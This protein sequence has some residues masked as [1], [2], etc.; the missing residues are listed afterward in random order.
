MQSSK[1]KFAILGCGRIGHRHI[2]M[3]E[4][5]QQTELV[6]LI[7]D[8]PA[9]E[10][11]GAAV[12]PFFNSLGD[13][14]ASGITCDVITIAT[15]NGLHAGHALACLDHGYHVLVEKPLALKSRDANKLME[16]SNATGKC[17]F[18]V[19]QNRFSKAAEWTKAMVQSDALGEIF[20][21]QANCFWNRDA[22]YYEGHEWHGDRQLDGGPLYTQFA[23][24]IDM[25]FWLFGDIE[26]IHGKAAN[27][28]HEGITDFADTGLLQFELENGG[29]GCL[30]FTTAVWGQNFESYIS[31]MGEKGTVKI[32]GQYLQNIGYC[33]VQDV[34]CPAELSQ[35]FSKEQIDALAFAQHAR[36]IDDVV[37]TLKEGTIDNN[38]SND[39]VKVVSIIER[40]S[41]QLKLS[42]TRTI[43]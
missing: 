17:V 41:N 6:A 36:V 23:H 29:I 33:N 35:S 21:V 9:N 24:F 34:H 15:P 22:R 32:N 37:N 26:N 2:K 5:N 20:L 40:M 28:T 11:Q 16:K 19:M 42:T 43:V 39:A 38:N 13:F 4:Q 27:F 8:K 31:I 30:N 10:I 14:F 3:L 18:T 7:D 25:L 12:Y 1:I